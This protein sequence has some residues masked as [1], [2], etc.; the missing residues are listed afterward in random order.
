MPITANKG[1]WAELYTL[2]KILLDNKV[3]AL[4][5]T[6]KPI[7][8]KFYHFLELIRQESGTE[9]RF[10]PYD[11][12]ALKSNSSPA[13]SREYL[14]NLNESFLRQIQ[15]SE[16]SSFSSECGEE[17][18]KIL[19]IRSLKAAASQ[20]IDLS[21]KLAGLHGADES[22]LGFSIKAQLGSPSTLFN[23]GAHTIFNYKVIGGS[24]DVNAINSI[25]TKSKYV[26]RVKAIYE[27]G[28]ILVFDN[29]NSDVFPLNLDLIDTSFQESLATLMVD[30]YRFDSK[31]VRDVITST[32]SRSSDVNLKNKLTHQI[33]NFLRAVALGMVPNTRWDGNLLAYGGYLIVDPNGNVGC[34]HLQNDDV[35]KDYLLENTKFETPAQKAGAFGEVKIDPDGQLSFSLNL[36]IKFLK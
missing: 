13:A 17:I 9:I 8:G 33:K 36:Q 31:R 2:V 18:M 11:S 34:L 26:D 10:A 6:A 3:P 29:V 16:G 23:A 22:E 19:G 21:A 25:S 35:F 30:S 32:A 5:K 15:H 4:D 20:K 24:V 27:S 12:V 1:E 7:R 28:A 14:S